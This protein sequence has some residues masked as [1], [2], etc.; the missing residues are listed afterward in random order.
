MASE[1]YGHPVLGYAL[2]AGG[3]VAIVTGSV[4]GGLAFSKKSAAEGQC[5]AQY[6]TQAGLD[7]ISMM[8]TSEAISTIGIGVGIAAAGAG[9]YF[10]LRSGKR[11]VPTA[12]APPA[13]SAPPPSA[14]LDP[15]VGPR[16]GGLALSGRF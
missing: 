12:D 14:R 1:S 3:A 2:L 9:V 11:P 16:L 5:N 7:D 15:L 4:F 6:C 8:K 10:V 13:A